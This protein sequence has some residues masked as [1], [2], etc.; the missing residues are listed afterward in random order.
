M[1]RHIFLCRHIC[2]KNHEPVHLWQRNLSGATV[3]A[4]A[5]LLWQWFPSMLLRVAVAGRCGAAGCA[6][7]RSSHLKSRSEPSHKTM[8][9]RINYDGCP[10]P[11]HNAPTDGTSRNKRGWMEFVRAIHN[12]KSRKCS[13]TRHTTEA[14]EILEMEAEEWYKGAQ[15]LQLNG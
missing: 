3:A 13:Y 14:S 5:C 6:K 1:C 9:K 10:S 4:L 7:P 15:T 11:H 8:P 2:P 12:P